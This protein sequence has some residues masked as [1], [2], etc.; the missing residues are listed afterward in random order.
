[1][2]RNETKR[3]SSGTETKRNDISLKR[4]ETKRKKKI[5]RFGKKKYNP[6]LRY[7]NLGNCQ[8]PPTFGGPQITDL[9]IAVLF[10]AHQ[11]LKILPAAPTFILKFLAVAP[12]L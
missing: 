7:G 3:Y 9:I 6:E 2:K 8:G 10:F 11:L 12:I 5:K 4:K 1:M